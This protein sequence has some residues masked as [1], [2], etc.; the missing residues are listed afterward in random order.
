MTLG[1]FNI[2]L[3]NENNEDPL[4]TK[5]DYLKSLKLYLFLFVLFINVIGCA[6]EINLET[7]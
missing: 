1:N 7:T 3:Y 5:I 6:V 4:N 2:L